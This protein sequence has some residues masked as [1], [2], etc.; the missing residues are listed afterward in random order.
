MSDISV[1]G[2]GAMGTALAIALINAGRD[3]AVWN[4]SR[5]KMEPL[6]TKGGTGSAKHY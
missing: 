5:E 6:V 2:L 3:V 1:I 4:R